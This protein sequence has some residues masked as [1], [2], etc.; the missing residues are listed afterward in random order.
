MRSMLPSASY[1]RSSLVPVN[2]TWPVERVEVCGVANGQRLRLL[3][4]SVYLHFLLE[5]TTSH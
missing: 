2:E 3:K 5:V 4:L 1:D